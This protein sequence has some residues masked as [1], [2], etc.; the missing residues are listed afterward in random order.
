MFT[1]HGEAVFCITVISLILTTCIN[2]S[3]LT[4]ICMYLMLL[5]GMINI[6][7]QVMYAL[8]VLIHTY[9][10][11]CSLQHATYC[12]GRINRRGDLYQYTHTNNFRMWE[13]MLGWFVVRTTIINHEAVVSKLPYLHHPNYHFQIR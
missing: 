9:I 6:V 10:D 13:Y 2:S 4:D 8:Q 3:S 1:G 5:G 12:W 7:L 11:G